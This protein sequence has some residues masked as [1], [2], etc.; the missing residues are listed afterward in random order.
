MTVSSLKRPRVDQLLLRDHSL[1]TIHPA[2]KLFLGN[3][4]VSKATK[5]KLSKAVFSEES[6]N[7]AEAGNSML[8]L[9]KKTVTSPLTDRT[10][11]QRERIRGFSANGLLSFCGASNA[12]TQKL[13][14][15]KQGTYSTLKDTNHSSNANSKSHDSPNVTLNADE[16]LGRDLAAAR[17]DVLDRIRKVSF[18][19]K[20]QK[21]RLMKQVS[22]GNKTWLYGVQL[23]QFAKI[24][25]YLNEEQKVYM[26]N[27]SN[28]QRR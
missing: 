14:A 22:E 5:V 10:N 17:Q 25:E 8:G 13:L 27:L 11:L 19:T 18:L 6:L 9:G 3:D 26:L 4:S 2:K 12:V 20:E 23:K 24:S 21:L 7:T 16:T 15:T 1:S 28:S